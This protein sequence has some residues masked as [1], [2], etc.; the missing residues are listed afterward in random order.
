MDYILR[1]EDKFQIV[2]I[3]VQSPTHQPRIH[4]MMCLE[5]LF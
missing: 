4:Q 3:C 1:K 5:K 2:S